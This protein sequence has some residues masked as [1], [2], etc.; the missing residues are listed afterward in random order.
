MMEVYAG[1]VSHMDD[2][3]GRVLDFL[4]AIG[5]RDNTLIVFLSDNGASAEGGPVGSINENL[6]FNNVPEDIERNLAMLDQLGTPATYNHYAWG[7]AW[8]GNTPFR[9]W[10]RETHRGG[11]SDPM[12]V[13]WPKGIAATGERRTQYLHAIDVVPTVLDAIGIQPPDRMR[14]IA[15][16]SYAWRQPQGLLRRGRCA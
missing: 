8:A 13:S 15:Q 2:Q 1:Y 6:F 10:K 11:I 9:R 12:V 7:W 14:G 16:S 4:D 3:F 5:Q